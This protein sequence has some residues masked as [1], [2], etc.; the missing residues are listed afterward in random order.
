MIWNVCVVFTE[1]TP[2]DDMTWFPKDKIA[3]AERKLLGDNPAYVT[4]DEVLTS[5]YFPNQ[6]MAQFPLKYFTDW[7][8][9][10]ENSVRR[11]YPESGLSVE[12]QVECLIDQATDS[13]LL[14]RLFIGW[15]A[16]V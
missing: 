14:G 10:E 6:K 8:L 2:T 3:I 16:W 4:R 13:N 1:A 5:V 9:G 12:A 7:C 11:A 15:D